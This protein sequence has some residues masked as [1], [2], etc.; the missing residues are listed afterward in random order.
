MKIAVKLGAGAGR[1]VGE[2][3]LLE[4]GD[5]PVRVGGGCGGSFMNCLGRVGVR[6]G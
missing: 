2:A 6:F 5:T 1:G 3:S 4:K